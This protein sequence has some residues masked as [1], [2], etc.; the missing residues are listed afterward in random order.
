MDLN[1]FKIMG[2]TSLCDCCEIPISTNYV[3]RS[4][5]E[6]QGHAPVFYW[7]CSP[8]CGEAIMNEIQNGTRFRAPI[9]RCK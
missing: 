1:E 2:I 5:K 9:P 8:Q 4:F 6:F 7:C 3:G